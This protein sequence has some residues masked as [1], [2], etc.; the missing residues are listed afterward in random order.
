MD[1][2]P[3]GLYFRDGS[4]EEDESWKLPRIRLPLSELINQN[5]HIK[6]KAYVNDY[7]ILPV[8]KVLQDTLDDLEMPIDIDG[9]PDELKIQDKIIESYPS[10]I[11]EQ[12]RK[13]FA[14]SQE[15]AN[16]G[17]PRLSQ[18]IRCYEII[19]KLLAF[20][21]LSDLWELMIK[22]EE[23]SVQSDSLVYFNSF[24]AIN[25][26][27]Y[28][29]Y[30]YLR[31]LNAAL[32]VLNDNNAT[33]FIS[34]LYKLKVSIEKEDELH[35]A[36]EYLEEVRAALSQNRVLATNMEEYCTQGEFHLSELLKKCAFLIKYR[37]VTVKDI[38]V[39]K[40]RH[41]DP[42]F[43]LEI[44]VLRGTDARRIRTKS[45]RYDQFTDSHSVLLVKNIQKIGKNL[46]LSPFI[47]DENALSG[48]PNIKVFFFN[49][50]E[51]GKK[52]HFEFVD[53]QTDTISA[54]E[55]HFSTIKDQFDAF[56]KS[57]G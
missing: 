13:L 50:S 15:M 53:T 30:N 52:Y 33:P 42:S 1:S 18:L 32:R 3:W 46:S 22:Q 17:L 40:L 34:E 27:N 31:L 2:M 45:R 48:Y 49:Y 43:A 10:P 20:T 55:N 56:K 16:I 41:K 19:S 57:L 7:L 23:I 26:E 21:A 5:R 54:D 9:D 35:E 39:N 37:L 8:F 28:K 6:K 11:G 14:N 51:K 24:F 29:T 12:L 47:I 36:S 4:S 44:G 25:A 38:A